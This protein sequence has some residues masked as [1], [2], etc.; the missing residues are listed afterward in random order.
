[1]LP[2]EVHGAELT[3]LPPHMA[4]DAKQTT[5]G[6]SVPS[7]VTQQQT[8]PTL[9]FAHRLRLF[10]SW[11]D[12]LP[13]RHYADP[14]HTLGAGFPRRPLASI[15]PSQAVTHAA[16]VKFDL[17]CTECAAL[18]LTGSFGSLRHRLSP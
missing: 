4:S 10:N 2:R 7:H 6:I 1:V 3:G 11:F 16:M 13:H 18:A 9:R 15:E 14:R 12:G 8:A 17:P 5:A